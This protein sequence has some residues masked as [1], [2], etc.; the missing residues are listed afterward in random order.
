MDWELIDALG[1]YKRE[2]SKVVDIPLTDDLKKALMKFYLSFW[3]KPKIK[4][5]NAPWKE[6]Q[7]VLI[8]NNYSGGD[9]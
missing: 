4:A 9:E 8:I 7:D 5:F 6:R 3:V 1:S 2:F